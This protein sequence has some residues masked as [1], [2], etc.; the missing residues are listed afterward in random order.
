MYIIESKREIELLKSIKMKNI[1]NVII[2]FFSLFSGLLFAQESQS[3]DSTVNDKI[4]F[5]YKYEGANKIKKLIFPTKT[6]LLKNDEIANVSPNGKITGVLKYSKSPASKASVTIYNE[7]STIISSF[8]VAPLDIIS[9][10]D[11]GRFAIYGCEP[12][13]A[14]QLPR[15]IRFYTIEGEE[16]IPAKNEFGMFVYAV[17]SEKDDIVVVAGVEEKWPK[18]II[19]ANISIY[20]ENFSKIGEYK[21]DDLSGY[22]IFRAPLIDS[23][24]DI[25]KV[26]ISSGSGVNY[27]TDTT[28][29]DFSG[30]ELKME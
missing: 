24:K 1:L 17:F 10:A 25:I 11:D 6:L 5:E 16:I 14:I 9:M 4:V 28:Y 26:L 30:T 22:S 12:I 3:N 2:I 19:H 13:D 29:I 21:I 18:D 8:E 7:F 23:N 15:F 27:K 20:D